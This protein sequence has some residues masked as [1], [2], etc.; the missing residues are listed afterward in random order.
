MALAQHK[1]KRHSDR[2][3]EPRAN[4]AVRRAWSYIIQKRSIVAGRGAREAAG[5]KE[6]SGQT[7]G[8]CVFEGA[9]EEESGEARTEVG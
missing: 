5:R 6:S 9:N 8:A 4:V 1:R 7:A 3:P 2:K